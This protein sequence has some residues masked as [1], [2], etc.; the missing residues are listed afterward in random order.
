MSLTGG[1]AVTSALL[2]LG[3][4]DPGE[5]PN[6]SEQNA[7]LLVAN[8]MLA[9]W[10]QEQALAI[11]ILISEQDQAGNMFIDEQKRA[12]DPLV[13]SFVLAAGSYTPPSYTAG[14]YAAG[15]VPNFPDLTTAQTFPQGYDWAIVIG[16]AVAL[17]P[18]YG[19]AA[20]AS[21]EVLGQQYQLA[22][23]QCNPVPGRIPVPGQGPQ[24]AVAAPSGGS[25]TQTP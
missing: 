24:G 1:Q 11:Q 17:L 19:S 21:V 18:Q 9:N 2:Q 20:T 22:K 7:C 4:F 15:S 16:L 10:Y 8:Q 6:T 14:S 23:A 12:T 5:T 13:A 25:Q 3:V